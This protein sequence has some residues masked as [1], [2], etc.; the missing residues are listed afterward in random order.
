MQGTPARSTGSRSTSHRR[1]RVSNTDDAGGADGDRTTACSSFDAATPDG[2]KLAWCKKSDPASLPSV[3]ARLLVGRPPAAAPLALDDE[4]S[5][6]CSDELP[7]GNSGGCQS[8]GSRCQLSALQP[9]SGV[10]GE[11]RGGAVKRLL[12]SLRRLALGRRVQYRAPGFFR[13]A[14]EPQ[15]LNL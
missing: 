12:S 5:T 7:V 1:R 2:F 14:P 9:S 4:S 15:S 10:G 11:S 8:L 3:H 13:N 6:S